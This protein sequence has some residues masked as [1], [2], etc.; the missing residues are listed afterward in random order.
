MISKS[1]QKAGG[2]SAAANKIEKVCNES[3]TKI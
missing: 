2:A 1:L 3:T